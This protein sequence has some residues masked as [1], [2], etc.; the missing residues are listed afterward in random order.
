[1]QMPARC[2]GCMDGRLLQLLLRFPGREWLVTREPK[3]V[4]FKSRNL[5][6]QIAR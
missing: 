5:S 6:P 1:M 3:G 2:F 4:T